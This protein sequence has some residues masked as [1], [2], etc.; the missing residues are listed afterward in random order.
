VRRLVVVLLCLAVGT[1]ACGDDDDSSGPD[2][3]PASTTVAAGATTTSSS[4]PPSTTTTT[5]V[6]STTSLPCATVPIPKTPVTS[7]AAT[8]E[9]YLTNV[10]E[11]GDRCVDHVVFDFTAPGSGPPPYEITYGS[12]PFSEDG[13]GETIPVKGTAFVVVRLTPAYS[14]NFET[15]EPTYTGPKR[16]TP[17]GAK[18]VREIVET[19]DFESVITWVIGLD[20]KRAFSVQAT[21]APRHQLV[22]TIG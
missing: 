11:L 6:L 18:H 13:S 22:V 10:Q 9:V 16:I 19:G 14:R 20:T 4:A 12:P 15:N 2:D 17:T 1:A 3:P 8:N 5:V 21:G 7:P